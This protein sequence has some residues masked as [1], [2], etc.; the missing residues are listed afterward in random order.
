[1]GQAPSPVRTGGA[2]VLHLADALEK[3]NRRW[4]IFAKDA[5]DRWVRGET[6][7]IIAGQQ[8]GFAGGPLY[9]LSKIATLLRMKRDFERD[10]K[11]A[12]VFFWLA[13][14]DHDF[15]EVAQLWVPSRNAQRDLLCIRAARSVESKLAVGPQ[16]VPEPLKTEL[17]S[18][19]DVGDAAWLREGIT[20]GDCFAELV[21]SIFGNEVILVDSLLPELRR[22]GKPLFD[23]I[24][25]RWDA[26][27]GALGARSHELSGAGYEPQVAPRSESYSLLFEL[28]DDFARHRIEKPRTVDA[29]RTSTSAL[30]RPLLQDFVFQPDI[31][32]GGPAE[33]SYYAQLAP[34]HDILG[35]AMPRVALRGHALVAPNRTLRFLERFG[36]EPARVFSSADDLLVEREPEGVATIRHEADEG[37]EELMKRIERIGELALPADHALARRITKSIGHIE[38]HFD[39]LTERAIQGLVRKEKERYGAAKELVGTLYPDRHVQERIVAWFSYWQQYGQHLVDAMTDAIQPDAPTF[40]IIGL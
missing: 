33:V 23:S 19:Y 39:K 37:R 36:I 1:G 18:L 38:Y 9:T 30:T 21:A 34:L 32:V 28:D 24:M 12:T 11:P 35:I 17:R 16:P 27:E 26:L 5:L 7:T 4:G 14:E 2:P 8:V 3:S 20:F 31:F 10:G 40:E 15:D 6:T 22:T 13:T 25:A 29:E